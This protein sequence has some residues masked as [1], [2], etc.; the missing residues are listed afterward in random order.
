APPH[1]PAPTPYTTLL[2]SAPRTFTANIGGL[3]IVCPA[4]SHG[5][6][7]ITNLRDPLDDNGHGTHVSGTIGAVGNNG[8]GVVGVNWTASIMRS[9]EHT[10]ELQSRGQLVC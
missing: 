7:A 5:F 8:V 3:P 4:G 9:E 2:R 6:N 10:S 1:H